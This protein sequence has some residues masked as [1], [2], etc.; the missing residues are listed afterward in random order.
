MPNYLDLKQQAAELEAKILAA[1][2]KEKA[3]VVRTIREQI[4]LFGI[5]ERDL[6][7]KYAHRATH[8]SPVLPKYRNPQTGETW[9]GR[10]REP[11]WIKD[12][13]RTVF[14]IPRE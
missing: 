1:R 14:Q 10:G 9:S 7:S 8:R 4:A 3:A 2:Q 5:T 12:K 11:R 6:F 13:D